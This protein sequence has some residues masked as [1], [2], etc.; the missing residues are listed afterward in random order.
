[1]RAPGATAPK[2]RRFWVA[3][4]LLGAFVLGAWPAISA[5]THASGLD[6]HFGKRGLVVESVT[7][8]GEHFVFGGVARAP[9]G[10]LFGIG[11][12]DG[13]RTMAWTGAGRLAVH[14]NDTTA[15]LAPLAALLRSDGRLIGAGQSRGQFGIGAFGRSLRPDAGFADGGF[16]TVTIP[17]SRSATAWAVAETAARGLVVGGQ[18]DV[19]G[20]WRWAL[21][22]VDAAGRLDPTF[23]A[24]GVV[25]TDFPGLGDRAFEDPARPG[26]TTILGLALEPDGKVV[27]AGSAADVASGKTRALVARYLPD[28]DLDPT[29]GGGDG[30]TSFGWPGGADSRVSSVALAPYPAARGDGP[31]LVGGYVGNAAANRASFALAKL[32]PDGSLDRKFGRGGRVVT[33]VGGSAGATGMAVRP[34]GRILLAG[35]SEDISRLFVVARYRLDGRPDPQ[36]GAFGLACPTVGNLT[37]PPLGPPDFSRTWILGLPDGRAL[38]AGQVQDLSDNVIWV[39][40]MF[41]PAFRAALDCFAARPPS[42]QGHRRGFLSVALSRPGRFA[43]DVIDRLPRPRRLGRVAFGRRAAGTTRIPWSFEVRSHRIR[44]TGDDRYRLVPLITARDGRVLA[45]GPSFALS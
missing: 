41:R 2:V 34:D 20:R 14:R 11:G 21:A 3:G 36:F 45:R 38:L 25:T 17:S 18:A 10:R 39:L 30:W 27:A 8:A 6:P 7:E 32:R 28:G 40:A 1:M 31:I 37:L 9:D 43:I 12:A 15:P 5:P 4:S 26:R 22:R 33:D 24:G 19:G 35:P 29:F 42:R 23:G 44:A 16:S 13:L